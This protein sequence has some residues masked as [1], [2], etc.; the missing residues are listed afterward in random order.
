MSRITWFALVLC[1]FAAWPAHAQSLA[2][3]DFPEPLTPVRPATRQELDRVE[4]VKLYGLAV[5]HERNNR[6][7]E[8]M[9]TLEEAMR[10][11]P[12]SASIYRGLIPLYVALDRGSD[13]LDAC[14]RVLELDRDDYETGYLYARQLR[15]LDRSKEALAILEKIIKVPGL[16]EQPD[17]HAQAAFDLGALHEAAGNWS[18]AEA[19]FREVAAILDHPIAL[20]ETK[21]YSREEIDSQCAET[22]ERLGRVCL[23]AGNA[24]KAIDAYHQAQKKDPNRAPRLA[25]NLAEVYRST[26]R[27]REALAS[28]NEYLRTL[29]Q[30]TDGYELKIKL[31]QQLN[32]GIDVLPELEAAAGRD[33]FNTAL[34]LLLASE[35]RKAR[36]PD[37]AKRIYTKLLAVTP[38]AEVYRGL[39]DVY[40]VEGRPGGD[41]ALR[42]LDEAVAAASGKDDKPGDAGAAANARAMLQ[43]LRDDAESV[44]RLLEAAHRALLAGQNLSFQ[45]RA[46]LASLAART[47]QLDAA[48]ELYRSCLGRPGG[49]R[50]LEQEVYGGLLRVLLQA[51]KFE[52]V[53]EICKEGLEKAQATNRVMFHIDMAHALSSLNRMK[54]A[55]AAADL[56][57]NESSDKD[58]LLCRRVRVEIFAQAEKFPQAEAECQALLKEYNQPGEVRDIRATLSSVHS[59]ARQYAKAEEQLKLILEADPNDAT[60]NNDLGYIW[61]DQNKN[62][63]EAERLIRKALELD[64]QQKT[65]G[66]KVTLDAD[67][68]N[69]AFIDSL[70]WVLF[71]KG[72]H[73]AARGELEKAAALAT[74]A[75][76][77]VVWDHLGDV[78]FR[79]DD[80]PKA[81]Q[82]WKKAADLYDSGYRR[83]T[84]ERYKEIQQKLMRHGMK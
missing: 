55:L 13:A 74:G 62:L 44:R 22:F 81:I 17:L 33:A 45:T 10:L 38:T 83:K 28:I 75:D 80:K 21:P 41:H 67:Q 50:N 57:V 82:H 72:D 36:Q 77:P 26:S 79:Q 2:R 11:D 43:V 7:V 69:A 61:A 48:E 24:D 23:R 59:L 4:A 20:L 8:A 40:K 56:A 29:P 1:V 30:G 47:R 16:R 42:Q 66:A 5:V 68:D 71:R 18:K 39:F 3:Q 65:S 12:N 52:A 58:R 25:F 49:L 60:A 34:K 14:K 54:E 31:L 53:L 73:A 78:C 32:R 9:R 6:L 76:D 63:D 35:Y 27:P 70:G 15:V 19:A 51:H 46:L 37:G 84:D 64:R